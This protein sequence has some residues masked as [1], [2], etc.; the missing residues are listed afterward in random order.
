MLWFSPLQVAWP[1]F[2]AQG[3]CV[4]GIQMEM[5]YTACGTFPTTDTSNVIGSAGLSAQEAGPATPII[6]QL[7][8]TAF[9]LAQQLQQ[10]PM[11][12]KA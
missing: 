12:C 10:R 2:R 9:A 4:V 8:V 5:P 7:S 3:V 11:V 1:C 6:H